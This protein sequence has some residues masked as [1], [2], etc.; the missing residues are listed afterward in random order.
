MLLH[1]SIAAHQPS[2]VS[3]VLAQ[4][5]GGHLT[6]CHFLAGGYMVYGASG[7]LLVEVYPRSK[8]MIPGQGQ[9]QPSE[10]A[11][12]EIEMD[13]TATHLAL[14]T[15]LSRQAIESIAA[16]H[17]WRCLYTRRANRFNVI[18]LWLENRQLVELILTEDLAEA[19]QALSL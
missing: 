8:V 4:L 10:F 19:K 17:D 3:A 12:T 7:D 1:A 11:D 15:Q 9:Q 16:E 2:N 18:E 6:S 5:L 14:T 13:F